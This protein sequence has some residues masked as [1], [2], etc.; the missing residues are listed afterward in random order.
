VL[1]YIGL[2]WVGRQ[3]MVPLRFGEELWHIGTYLVVAGVFLYIYSTF[4][5][6]LTHLARL[7]ARLEGGDFSTGYDEEAD[8]RPDGI[9]LVGRA[10]NRVRSQL[11]GMIT[12]DPV[13]GCLNERGLDQQI[14]RETE[15][16]FRE[17]SEM[18]IVAL[19]IDRFVKVNERVG[20][21][22]GD[23]VLHD[24]GRLLRDTARAW[25]SVA[26]PN[27][28]RFVIVLPE[29]SL[30][31]AREVAQRVSEALASREFRAA[32]VKI[33]LRVSMGV[34]ANR[35]TEANADRD[36]LSRAEEAL[37]KAKHQGGD[38]IE[39]AEV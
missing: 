38:R 8:K 2:V 9:T 17:G 37:E 29:T 5:D 25:D 7:F 24:F 33:K 3:R 18:A 11:A 14:R 30:A 22:A 35:M 36:L 10:Y 4:V 15:R 21:F 32:D 16:A 26:R 12:T 13:S 34:A 23:K 39:V 20:N 6:R 28:D 19:D 31:G 27:Q 1:S